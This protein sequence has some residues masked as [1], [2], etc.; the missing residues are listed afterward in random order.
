MEIT[1]GKIRHLHSAVAVS[2]CGAK[3]D[4]FG[5]QHHI[6]NRQQKTYFRE[7]GDALDFIWMTKDKSASWRI[8][9]LVPDATHICSHYCLVLGRR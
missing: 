6:H 3:I 2:S 5:C 1:E 9:G 4:A 8:A 7:L